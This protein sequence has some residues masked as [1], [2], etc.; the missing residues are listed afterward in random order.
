MITSWNLSFFLYQII[1][2]YFCKN[3]ALA[4]FCHNILNAFW[5]KMLA[6]KEGKYKVA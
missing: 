1:A 5:G 3:E 2:G 4:V 6:I